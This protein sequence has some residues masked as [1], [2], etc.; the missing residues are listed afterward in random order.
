MFLNT[1]ALVTGALLSV[2]AAQID[3]LPA[4][5][6][7]EVNPSDLIK[8]RSFATRDASDDIR[9]L[10]IKDP[11]Q[12]TGKFVKRVATGNEAFDPTSRAELFWGAYGKC[13]SRHNNRVTLTNHVP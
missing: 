13:P 9:L 12:L 11:G 4:P 10:P 6:F 7:R 3:A 5:A 2:L 1:K 8:H